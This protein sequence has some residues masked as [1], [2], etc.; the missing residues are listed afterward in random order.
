MKVMCSRATRLNEFCRLVPRCTGE[1]LLER[2]AQ[3]GGRSVTFPR[4]IFCGA[5]NYGSKRGVDAVAK[6]CL[7][8]CFGT[9]FAGNILVCD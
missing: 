3:F 5:P 4:V 1:E 2:I 6:L 7:K 9:R 8:N